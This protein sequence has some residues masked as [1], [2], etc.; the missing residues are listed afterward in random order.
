MTLRNLSIHVSSVVSSV[1]RFLSNSFESLNKL[2][3]FS[4]CLK[5]CCLYFLSLP[6]TR[7]TS[8][9]SEVVSAVRSTSMIFESLTPVES[10][11]GLI[12][13]VDASSCNIFS[14]LTVSSFGSH[15]IP[16]RHLVSLVPPLTM[17]VDFCPFV[18]SVSLSTQLAVRQS[19]NSHFHLLLLPSVL[20][21]FFRLLFLLFASAVDFVYFPRSQVLLT[22]SIF[23]HFFLRNFLFQ[24]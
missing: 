1:R 11:R 2:F 5:S 13:S 8:G 3:L 4:A 19:R 17:L 24:C 7:L 20:F 12:N 10:L 21:S 6:A 22:S 9:L 16:K 15:Y 14:G 23:F 18:S